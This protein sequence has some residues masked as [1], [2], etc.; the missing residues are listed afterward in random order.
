MLKLNWIKNKKIKKEGE[1]KITELN[2]TKYILEIPL[3][4]LHWYTR[5]T[6]ILLPHCSIGL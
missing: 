6:L 1:E 3:S 4:P 2:W 5:G